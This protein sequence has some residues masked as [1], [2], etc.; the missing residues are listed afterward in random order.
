MPLNKLV[1]NRMFYQMEVL[2]ACCIPTGKK[3][4][5]LKI[6]HATQNVS[7][8]LCYCYLLL[9]VG[10]AAS[11]RKII[12]H[13]TMFHKPDEVEHHPSLFRFI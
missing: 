9:E 1:F 13:K 7:L 12:K 4:F 6:L 2:I 10:I 8:L 5:F 3:D 11:R